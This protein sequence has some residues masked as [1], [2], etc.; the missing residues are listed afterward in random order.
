MASRRSGNLEAR[1][2]G[3]SKEARSQPPVVAFASHGRPVLLRRLH[4]YDYVQDV[5]NGPE[6]GPKLST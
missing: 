6:K 4:Q 5:P 1:R 2:S 3:S